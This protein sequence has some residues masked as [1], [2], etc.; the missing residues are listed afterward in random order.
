MAYFHG[1]VN[2]HHVIRNGLIYI[3]SFEDLKI[4]QVILSLLYFLTVVVDEYLDI[5]HRQIL[6]TKDLN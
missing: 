4:F 5:R 1:S 6:I 3:S 2:N